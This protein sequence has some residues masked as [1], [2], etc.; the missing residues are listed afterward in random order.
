MAVR[1]PRRGARLDLPGVRRHGEVGDRGV[2][3]LAAAMADHRG[4]GVAAREVDRVERLGERADLVHLDQ[5][6]VRRAL[7]K[8]RSRNSLFV[9]N[10]SSPTSCTREPSAPVRAAQPSQSSSPSGS[11]SET[12]REA[13]EQVGPER[14]HV[15]GAP[16]G[17]LQAVSP[18]VRE[19]GHR[20]VHRGRATSSPGVRP[21][22]SI[23]R[24]SHSRASATP[25]RSRAR[26][27]LRR[28][29]RRRR[30]RRSGGC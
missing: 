5:D 3:G 9:T 24:R 2:L 30:P 20:R 12:M 13:V 6:R 21:A 11:S 28:P 16:V 29:H 8:P 27:R 23:A 18:V 14:D 19:L 25:W 17:T 10:R 7:T 4:V 22:F 1:S 15:L 26:T